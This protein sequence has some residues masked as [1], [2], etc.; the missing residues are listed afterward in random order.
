[1]SVPL[2]FPDWLMQQM[3]MRGMIPADLVRSTGR[4]SSTVSRWLNPHS[5]APRPPSCF[6]IA[7]A[8]AMDP[9]EVLRAAGHLP[10]L[11]EESATYGFREIDPRAIAIARVLANDQERF[12][13]WL[14]IGELFVRR[15]SGT[16]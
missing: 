9:N 12:E 6:L 13:E 11:A 10:A 1:M 15:S 7:K 2:S 5:G 8:L 4:N 3:K 14:E 16:R